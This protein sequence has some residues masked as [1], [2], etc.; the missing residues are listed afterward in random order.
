[1]S[2]T[3]PATRLVEEGDVRLMVR[4][5]HGRVRPRA[6][7]VR[8][9][10]GSAAARGAAVALAAEGGAHRSWL[11]TYNSSKLRTAT[12]SYSQRF[13]INFNGEGRLL[14]VYS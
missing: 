13:A 11:Y 3:V 9:A 8:V 4:G 5:R 7:R 10:A 12:K 6:A 1:M 2:T 14:P